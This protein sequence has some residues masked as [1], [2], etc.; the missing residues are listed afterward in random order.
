MFRLLAAA[1]G[2]FQSFTGLSMICAPRRWFMTAPGVAATGPFNQHFVIDAGLAFL[3]TGIAF[4]VCACNPRLK[5]VGLG[6][7]GFVV[8]HA[9]FHLL[10]L[11]MGESAAPAVDIVLAIPAFLGLALTLPHKEMGA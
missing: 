7:S 6:A 8:L 5:L 4:F 1:V 2:L 10:H 9:L 11:A 3:A